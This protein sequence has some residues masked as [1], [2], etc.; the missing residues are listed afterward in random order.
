[1]T[2]YLWDSNTIINYLEGSLPGS[3]LE[4]LDKLVNDRPVISVISQME[5]LGWP[6][7]SVE[8]LELPREFISISEV[9]QLTPEVI[10]QTIDIRQQVKIKLPDAIIAATAL[11]NKLVL[12]TSN[13]SDFRQI[14]NLLLIDPKKSQ[15][16]FI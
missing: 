8:D 10:S 5:L 2:Q 4:T 13:A 6:N 12:L 7:A 14:D 11:V 1:M 3:S 16:E 9:L 15:D